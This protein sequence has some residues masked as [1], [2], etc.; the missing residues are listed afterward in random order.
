MNKI[1]LSLFSLL[2][3]SLFCACDPKA[4][5]VNEMDM[6]TITVDQKI[7]DQML[8]M[9]DQ[10]GMPIIDMQTPI[11]QMTNNNDQLI[12]DA[13][14]DQNLGLDQDLE[15]DATF[16]S[17]LSMD[18]N[19]PLTDAQRLNA[20]ETLTLTLTDQEP[21]VYEIEIEQSKSL[22]I[23]TQ[24]P[25]QCVNT[26]T[27]IDVFVWQ[28]D[29]QTFEQI[30]SNDDIFVDQLCSLVY[31]YQL[32]AERYQFKIST[33]QTEP[34]SF[35]LSLEYLD[36]PS[37]YVTE[38]C[39]QACRTDDVIDCNLACDPNFDYCLKRTVGFCSN[40]DFCN[41]ETEMC[42]NRLSI[43]EPCQLGMQH[44]CADGLY[45]FTANLGIDPPTCQ[46]YPRINDRCLMIDDRC[47]AQSFCYTDE[48]SVSTCRGE[49]ENLG[50]PCNSIYQC[51]NDAWVCKGTHATCQLPICGNFETEGLEKCDDGNLTLGDGCD[52]SCVAER[53]ITIALPGQRVNLFSVI[54]TNTPQMIGVQDQT[55]QNPCQ[56]NNLEEHFEQFEIFNHSDQPQRV[57]L[58][59]YSAQKA[60]LMVYQSPLIPQM[61]TTGCSQAITSQIRATQRR[62]ELWGN[63]LENLNMPP[64]SSL[65]VV[66]SMGT[67]DLIGQNRAVVEVLTKG[68][69][70]GS[71]LNAPV[72]INDVVIRG[73]LDRNDLNWNRLDTQCMLGEFE[74]QNL[75]H[76]DYYFLSNQSNQT[77]SV[78]LDLSFNDGDGYLYLF[79]IN[80]EQAQV[81]DVNVN[82][83]LLGAD[84][85]D[86]DQI[87][88]LRLP[89]QSQM[90][91]L[92]SSFYPDIALGAYSLTIHTNGCGDGRLNA[93]EMC[94]DGNLEAGD[95]CDAQCQV[96][97]ICGDGFTRGHEEC[98]DGNLDSGDGCHALCQAEPIDISV[99]AEMV[100]DG[101]LSFRDS[102]WDRP[103]DDCQGIGEYGTYRK[104]YRLTNLSNDFA[105][106]T[107]SVDWTQDGLIYLYEDP[108]NAENPSLCVRANDDASGN[109]LQ[110]ALSEIKIA[111]QSTVV[112]VLSA[113]EQAQALSYHL[114]LK[115]VLANR[116][117]QCQ[118]L[119]PSQITTAYTTQVYVK[120]TEL[121]L[122]END[123][124]DPSIVAEFGFA[125]D[126]IDPIS[127]GNQWIW[128]SAT[129]NQNQLVPQNWDEYVSAI[130]FPSTG[131][132]DY[133]FRVSADFGRT[134]TLCDLDGSENGYQIEQAGDAQIP[135]KLIINEV[136]YDNVGRDDY[137]FIE[138]YNNGSIPISLANT[139]VL[140]V[141]G[142]VDG[143]I[144]SILRTIALDSL[145]SIQ[146]NEYI[147]ISMPLLTPLLS[148]GTRSINL[149]TA[150]QNDIEAVAIEKVNGSEKMILDVISYGGTVLNYQE[151]GGTLLRDS[152]TEQGSLNRCPNGIDKNDNSIDF[153]WLTV[154]SPGN[155]NPCP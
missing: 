86:R 117:D 20:G 144:T 114:K 47:P 105:F 3:I 126:G 87:R 21:L 10:K 102:A 24:G 139:N 91:L 110:S 80:P 83:C 130:E 34:F 5:Q 92:V 147:V 145:V 31:L 118:L 71:E 128:Q 123:G 38:R 152:Q 11:D 15:T 26:D 111:P 29:T 120:A 151:G 77:K 1:N 88:D 63:T 108:F 99:Q 55:A 150:M 89:P 27:R 78:D 67:L 140:L 45:C 12:E 49:P 48:M 18:M 7:A 66:V 146:A 134:W 90:I 28:D 82:P 25:D 121:N 17:M 43:N 81:F 52:A 70:S 14:I 104:I 85:I 153:Q 112:L 109:Y 101:D 96:E 19:V 53:S 116:I 13:Q 41:Q 119:S 69:E 132:Y 36:I 33:Q 142:G 8:V 56:T 76:Y 138:L 61:P 97:V 4:T 129:P 141:N 37:V 122:T 95:A 79:Q 51:P 74:S 133:A 137:E 136:D 127:Q 42:E 44:E 98:D 62:D 32:A 154:P 125:L 72:E 23:Y 113:F 64:Q 9:M 39:L 73:S 115:T 65:W 2:I 149:A 94:D 68:I 40:Q 124:F 135:G 103:F 50:D 143:S 148:M 100:L 131:I 59:L 107:P 58:K 35:D 93:N 16:D 75:Y 46:N 6:Q 106:V 30:A 155:P 22:R 57:N 84:A 60:R 54:N